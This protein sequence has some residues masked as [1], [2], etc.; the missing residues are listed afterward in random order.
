MQPEDRGNADGLRQATG[1]L[2][3]G[4]A[5][6]MAVGLD[7]DTFPRALPAGV[8]LLSLASLLLTIRT[9]IATPGAST[10]TAGAASHWRLPVLCLLA[11][12]LL[13]MVPLP[14][15]LAVLTGATR[16]SQDAI[17][18]RALEIYS[19]IDPSSAVSRYVTLSR[20]ASGTYRIVLLA[21]VVL[22]TA[23][24]G[25]YSGPKVRT[26]TLRLIFVI[27]AAVAVSG[28]AG[29]WI[30]P[31]GNTLWWVFPAPLT[32]KPPAA[33]FSSRNHFSAFMALLAGI[34]LLTAFLSVKRKVPVTATLVAL[35]ALFSA[36]A[37]LL[38]S[39]GGSM[40]LVA[41]I[42]LAGVI[43]AA[44]GRWRTVPVVAGMLLL[45]VVLALTVRPVRERIATLAAMDRTHSF[46]TRISAC[47]DAYKVWRE[48]PILGGGPN[49]FRVLYP[50]YRTSIASAHMT[51]VEN[52]YM[53]ALAEGGLVGIGL[54]AWL[55][56]SVLRSVRSPGMDTRETRFERTVFLYAAGVAAFNSLFDFPFHVPAYAMTLAWFAGC[57]LPPRGPEPASR[58]LLLPAA[59]AALLIA[60][61]AWLAGPRYLALDSP[62]YLA[63]ADTVTVC[64]S[65]RQ[66]PTSWH[67]WYY[68][69]RK[70]VLAGNPDSLRFGRKCL[71][72]AVLY[73]PNN[74]RLWSELGRLRQSCGDTEGAQAAAIRADSLRSWAQQPDERRNSP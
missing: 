34:P 62:R 61:P 21:M 20:N 53:Q 11:F 18:D 19:G 23:A 2:L 6:L 29:Q 60:V 59:V 16:Q 56:L 1:W 47:R 70:A 72:Q 63:I 41:A 42:P 55:A 32:F 52:E 35:A 69:G 5:Y 17:A 3:A 26:R 8:V 73:D 51:H 33:G 25:R 7:A 74:R 67:S 9:G 39:R 14:E 36:S 57:A 58:G 46:V 54:L 49:A 12:I 28:I 4:V 64:R 68:L 27:G 13:H 48:Y 44:K 24:M 31:Q 10:A 30:I 43:L 22:L 37:L 50:Q 15:G 38:L 71:E 45:V 66:A 65:L 40:A